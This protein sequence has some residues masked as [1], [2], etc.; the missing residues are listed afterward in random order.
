MLSGGS[1]GASRRPGKETLVEEEDTEV[2][3]EGDGDDEVPFVPA[4]SVRRGNRMNNANICRDMMIN[5]AT[6][7]EEKYL[8]DQSDDEAIRRSW[9]LLGK[10]AT[11]QADV[12]FRFESLLGEHKKLSEA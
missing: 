10:C 2:D 12:I 6:P 4:W 3:I 1:E 7:K 5:L 8:D 9:L 11:A